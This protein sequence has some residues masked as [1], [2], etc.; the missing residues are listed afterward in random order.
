M[1]L[2]IKG[3]SELRERLERLRVDEVMAKALREQAEQ[4]AEAVRAG[5]SEP[6]GAGDHDRPWLRSGALRDSIGAQADGLQAV[7]GSSDPAAAPQEMGT[8]HLPPRPFLAPFGASMGQ[9]AARAI[10]IKVAAALD[11]RPDS[12]LDTMHHHPPSAI[13]PMGPGNG[14]LPLGLG[15]GLGYLL[16]QG[17]LTRRQPQ[18]AH[19]TVL[20]HSSSDDD[21]P[22]SAQKPPPGSKPINETERSGDHKAIKKGIQVKPTDDVR[23][24]P[25][26]D[27]WSQNPDG[28]WANHG[29]AGQFTGSG[30]ASGRRGVDRNRR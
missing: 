11:G 24:A 12:D 27:V 19:P 23:I 10:G 3:L 2:G 21:F 15:L 29:Y 20:E 28:T 4:I 8:Q 13:S 30:R 5:L 22:E 6:Q 18:P 17:A 7:V 14:L 26:G 1:R 25:N 9:D 16:L